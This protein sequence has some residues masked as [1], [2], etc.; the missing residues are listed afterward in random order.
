MHKI[1]PEATQ[2]TDYTDV[3]RK[4]NKMFEGQGP[5]GMFSLYV[6]L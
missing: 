4:E 6:F 2:K 3:S 1:L 5:E